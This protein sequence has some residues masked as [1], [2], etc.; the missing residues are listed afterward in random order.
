MVMRFLRHYIDE[1]QN[2]SSRVGHAGTLPQPELEL[3]LPRPDRPRDVRQG[4][5]AVWERVPVSSFVAGTRRS[6]QQLPPRLICADSAEDF[7][8]GLPLYRESKSGGPFVLPLYRALGRAAQSDVTLRHRHDALDILWNSMRVKA[9]QM[10]KRG[11]NL[12][13]RSL[14]YPVPEENIADAPPS[15]PKVS[16]ATMF[17]MPEPLGSRRTRSRTGNFL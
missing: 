13:P 12:D 3:Q 17:I 7:V 2:A 10:R 16:Q 5:V 4:S 11:T 6:D 8:C 14:R 15:A 9:L 1:I